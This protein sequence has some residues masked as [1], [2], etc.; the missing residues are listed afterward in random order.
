MQSAHTLAWGVYGPIRVL[1]A[2]GARG[3]LPEDL[4]DAARE[5]FAD[6]RHFDVRVKLHPVRYNPA[7][8]FLSRLREEWRHWIHI[9]RPYW[10]WLGVKASGRL[11]THWRF[12]KSRGWHDQ[13]YMPHLAWADVLVYDSASLYQPALQGGL[14]VVHWKA[15]DKYWTYNPEAIESQMAGRHQDSIECG[16]P[17]MLRYVTYAVGRTRAVDRGAV[18]WNRATDPIIA[19]NGK[20]VDF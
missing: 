17:L 7:G 15:R 9:D 13:S 4:L 2:T 20:R 6:H 16:D 18:R 14:P 1:I 10:R 8:R 12:L 3:H 5:A 19:E 11:P